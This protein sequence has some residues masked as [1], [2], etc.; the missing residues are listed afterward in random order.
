MQLTYIAIG[1]LFLAIVNN[2][3][4]EL[5]L[6]ISSLGWFYVFNFNAVVLNTFRLL[7]N[8]D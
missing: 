8:L 4:Y 2:G 3:Q 5:V 6:F 1:L 7:K